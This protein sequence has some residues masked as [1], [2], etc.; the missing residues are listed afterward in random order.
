MYNSKR[1]L[2]FADRATGHHLEYIELLLKLS[3][4]DNDNIYVFLI[5]F[6]FKKK[7]ENFFLHCNNKSSEMIYFSDSVEL[8]YNQSNYLLRSFYFCRFI[9]RHLLKHNIDHVIVL[10]LMNLLPLFPIFFRRNVSISG[11]VY[12][13]Y[14]HRWKKSNWIVRI[15][16]L[17]KYIILTKSRAV[18][19]IFLINGSGADL[20]LNKLY[21]TSKFTFLPDPIK[22]IQRDNLKR[23]DCFLKSKNNQLVISH[24]GYLSKRKGTIEFLEAIRMLESASLNNYRFIFAGEVD[25]EIFA[26]FHR[27]LNV[28]KEI[29][30]I[31]YI[32][33]FVDDSVL[34]SIC[35]SSD[36]L[37]IPYTNVEQSSGILGYSAQFKIPVIGP[38]I[39]LLGKLI[40]RYNLGMVLEN[41]DRFSLKIVMDSLN[42]SNKVIPSDYINE[43]SPESFIYKIKIKI[44]EKL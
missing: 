10:S 27:L 8:D 39:G 42:K 12:L 32:D 35:I 36:Y 41:V 20:Y 40:R 43:N 28:L 3:I 17:T 38:K 29:V 37:M 9:K 7:L 34:A 11:F 2:I 25:Q 31:T 30:D 16:D 15:L 26:E 44:S 23:I 21:G 6:S 18:K 4:E 1:F 24:F 33:G 13:I 19:D 14:L 5:P 22:Y